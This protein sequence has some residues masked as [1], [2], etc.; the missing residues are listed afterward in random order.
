MMQATRSTDPPTSAIAEANV[1]ASGKR[2]THGQ[3]VVDAVLTHPG[4]VG[5]EVGEATGLGQIEAMRRLADNHRT[6]R[7]PGG[8]LAQ[9]EARKGLHGTL[10]VSW[11]RAHDD[12]VQGVLL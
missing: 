3:R 9:G 5:T 2:R 7:N 10:E 8:V 12:A 6:D 11:W 1:T 4:L